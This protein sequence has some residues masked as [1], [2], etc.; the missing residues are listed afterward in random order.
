MK[1]RIDMLIESIIKD[2]F[3]NIDNAKKDKRI[4]YLLKDKNIFELS[5]REKE[6]LLNILTN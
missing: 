6:H 4:F 2:K 5:K 3:K 1:T